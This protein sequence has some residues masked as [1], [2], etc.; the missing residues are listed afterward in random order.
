MERSRSPPA[1]RER[2]A[3][4][5]GTMDEVRPPQAARA[6]DGADNAEPMAI[7]TTGEN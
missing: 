4:N 7:N 1:S 6:N 2:P 5:G 3:V